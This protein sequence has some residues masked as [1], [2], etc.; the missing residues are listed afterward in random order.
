MSLAEQKQ[1]DLFQSPAACR[2]FTSGHNTWATQ[3]TQW[4]LDNP[5][6]APVHKN[7]RLV[8]NGASVRVTPV[9]TTPIG[10]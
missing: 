10:R 8:K 2:F 5:K 3:F 1:P 7:T 6:F 9:A 4:N